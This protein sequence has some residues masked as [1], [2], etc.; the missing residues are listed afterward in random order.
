VSA[1]K[2]LAEGDTIG[3]KERIN[4][5]L[6]ND[7]LDTSVAENLGYVAGNIEGIGRVSKDP[8]IQMRLYPK[9]GEQPVEALENT[10]IKAEE[11]LADL[12]RSA[13][14]PSTAKYQIKDTLR[15]I[16]KQR[17]LFT[18]DN[19][20]PALKRR[21]EDWN[22]LKKNLKGEYEEKN[23]IPI[24]EVPDFKAINFK[25]ILDKAYMK[26]SNEGKDD[27]ARSLD[28]SYA[29]LDKA[30]LSGDEKAMAKAIREVDEAV[31]H[32]KDTSGDDMSRDALSQLIYLSNYARHLTTG[33]E[34]TK[35][36]GATDEHL[37]R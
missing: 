18:D 29:Q 5:V 15:Q 6:N 7:N 34:V 33:T 26:L 2:A 35:V 30:I 4:W 16:N 3:A 31:K 32:L 11:K 13:D 9:A 1:R 37:H 24:D 36:V 21:Q 23:I 25:E 10:M 27:L 8:F 12:M 20:R 28:D 22:K 17:Q 14:T 19:Y